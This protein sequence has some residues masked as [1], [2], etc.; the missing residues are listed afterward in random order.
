MS[1]PSSAHLRPGLDPLV[2]PRDVADLA[3]AL[4]SP[5]DRLLVFLADRSLVGHLCIAAE[6]DVSSRPL[7]DL[8]AVIAVATRNTEL[9]GLVLAERTAEPLRLDPWLVVQ[10]RGATRHGLRVESWVRF[11]SRSVHDVWPI[12]GTELPVHDP[13]A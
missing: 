9:T 2:D 1:S 7:D 13:L 8:F 11:D 5:R 10:V 3:A 12:V 4:M 6:L